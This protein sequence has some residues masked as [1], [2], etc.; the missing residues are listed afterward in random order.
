MHT[1]K[2]IAAVTLT[3]MLACSLLGG[4]TKNNKDTTS[5]TSKSTAAAQLDFSNSTLNGIVTS[6]D[7]NVI[8]LSLNGRMNMRAGQGKGMQAPDAPS[9]NSGETDQTPPDAPSGNGGETDQ[10][11]PDAPSGNNGEMGHMNTDNTSTVTL[12]ITDESVLQDIALSDITEGTFLTISFGDN[13][14]ITGVAKAE[15]GG[16]PGENPNS[17]SN[18]SV[19]T[20]TGANTITADAEEEGTSYTSEKADEN[21]LRIEGDISYLGANLNVTKSSGDTSNTEASDFYGLNASVL[22]LEGANLTLSQS[23]ISTTA[24][25]ANGVFAYGSGTAVTLKNTSITTQADNSGGVDVTG[26]ASITAENLSIETSGNSSAALRSDRGGGTLDVTAGDYTTNGTGSPA[27]YCTADIA[28]KDAKLTANASE[29]VVIEGNN[30]VTLENCQVT[31]NMQGTYQ[32]D[33]SENLHG[34]MIYQSMSGDAEEGRASFSVTGGSITSLNGDLIYSTN[35][36]SVVNLNHVALTPANDTL[37]RVCGNDGS[38]GWGESGSNGADMELNATEQTLTGKIIVDEI[39]S[40]NLSLSSNST[41]EGSINEENEGGAV[42]VTLDDTSTWKLTGDSYITS[43]EG[44]LDSIDM[45]GHTL[46]INGA[47]QKK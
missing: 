35:T 44:S 6:V 43:L 1:K 10:T 38:R 12:T 27:I 22:G 3:A 37:L 30:S 33:E 5:S 21:A 18:N 46:Y 24:K 25:G 11:P 23:A 7:D 17:S 9:G 26:G 2:K 15:M 8:T 32:G 19:N 34:I 31:G 42:T 20:G 29:G 16:N 36:S 28:V 40:L 45:N 47:A 41:L 4:C 13:N 14:Q 39:S